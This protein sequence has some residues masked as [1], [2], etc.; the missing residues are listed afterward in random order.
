MAVVMLGHWWVRDEGR[1]LVVG[2]KICWIGYPYAF[3]PCHHHLPD[4][5]R[6]SFYNAWPSSLLESLFLLLK[7]RSGVAKDSAL[8]WEVMMIDDV[9]WCH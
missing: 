5:G 1:A 9:Y 4:N 8:T 2:C 7:L 6:R 3:L